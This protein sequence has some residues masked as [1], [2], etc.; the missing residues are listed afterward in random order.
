MGHL[1]DKNLRSR[2]LCWDIYL[3][4]ILE[5]CTVLLWHRGGMSV[6]YLK[7]VY[8]YSLKRKCL[9]LNFFACVFVMLGKEIVSE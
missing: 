4:Q 5:H 2:I 1:F 9:L 6:D 7:T 8:T 3:L